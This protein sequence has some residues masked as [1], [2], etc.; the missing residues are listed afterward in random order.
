M[1]DLALLFFFLFVFCLFVVVFCVFVCFCSFLCVFFVYLFIYFFF[2]IFYFFFLGGGGVFLGEGGKCTGLVLL[3]PR[4]RQSYHRL[5][6]GEVN[7]KKI[8]S[9]CSIDLCRFTFVAYSEQDKT[10]KLR[11]CFKSTRNTIFLFILRGNTYFM[12]IFESSIV[13]VLTSL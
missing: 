13:I 4:A 12:F 7:V 2:F 9:K 6:D 3:V 5:G 10:L 1:F 8:S 11:V